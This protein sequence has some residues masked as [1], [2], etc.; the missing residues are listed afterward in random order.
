MVAG[1]RLVI[2][3]KQGAGKGTQCGRLSRHYGVPHVSTGD[4]F[5]A[6]V[7]AGTE[8]GRKANE[9]IS[10]GELVPDEVVI[11]VIRERLL[12]DDVA[13]GFL[14]DGFP[15]TVHQAE[16]FDGMPEGG[17]LDLV[18]D[19][20]APIDVVLERLAGRRVCL[21]C[22]ANYHVSR[23]P[24]V[25]WTCDVCGG[26]VVQREDDTKSA[27]RRRLELYEEQTAP[28]IRWYEH[29]GKLERVDGLGRPDEVTQ[30]LIKVIDEARVGKE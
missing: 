11:G 28:L 18:V 23:P 25:N 24:W 2:L 6:A 17:C 8:F 16:V 9:Y 22:G 5:R 29:R 7:K 26:Q 19:L 27:I 15:R 10:A 1:V 20:A 4:I 13:R 21:G 14:L 3:G 30:R 12:R